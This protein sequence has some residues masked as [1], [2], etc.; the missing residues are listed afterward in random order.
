MIKFAFVILG[1]AVSLQST[2]AEAKGRYKP[3]NI[4]FGGTYR[5][6]ALN[7]DTWRVTG[8]AESD[9]GPNLAGQTAA[10]RGAE[11]AKAAGFSFFQIVSRE[12]TVTMR[13]YRYQREFQPLRYATEM[14]IHGAYGT[15]GQMPC[16]IKGAMYC[17]FYEVDFVLRN[18]APTVL[19][20]SE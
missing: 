17:P 1:L 12:S 11:L 9:E 4:L 10:Y 2:A 7:S 8:L 16:E 5:D 18:L 3:F 14:K 19:G 15:E 6:Q 13:K 20:E